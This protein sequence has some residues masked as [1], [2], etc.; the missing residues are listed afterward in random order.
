MDQPLTHKPQPD[1]VIVW[2]VT[3][4]CNLRCKFCAYDR[5]LLRER[6]NADPEQILSFGRI[7]AEFQ[8]TT[9]EPVLV[10]WLGGEPF[11]WSHLR[12]LAEIYAKE[13]RLRI[14]TTTNGTTLHSPLLRGHLLECYSELTISVD[15]PG[16]FHDAS[17]G[18]EGGFSS[19]RA[20]VRALAQ[21]KNKSGREL[22]LR[23]NVVLMN[24][25]L[26]LLE[27]LCAELCTWGIQE[28]SFNQL[29][30]MDRP[31]FFPA[32]RLRPLDIPRLLEMLP[33]ISDSAADQGVRILGETEYIRRIA[34]TTSNRRLS[35]DDCRPGQDFLFIDEQG[36]VAPCSFTPSEYGV[37]ISEIRDCEDLVELPARFNTLRSERRSAFCEDCHS[38]QH[39]KKFTT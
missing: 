15:G 11:L 36:R 3:E 27:E 25:N 17:R 28:I 18:W 30:G 14:S 19:L 21:E 4:W 31:E 35:V 29:G 13:Y 1:M 9:G 16:S 39:F 26:G 2:R 6:R 12:A 23:A 7:L 8:Q 38:T 22:T 24:H 32:H 37:F 10:S 5:D 33:R 20:S 34:A